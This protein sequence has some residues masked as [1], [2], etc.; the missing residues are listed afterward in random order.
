[1]NKLEQLGKAALRQIVAA[2]NHEHANHYDFWVGL[3]E[4]A[5]ELDLTKLDNSKEEFDNPWSLTI[6]GSELLEE[7]E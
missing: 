4:C 5:S 7:D 2:D 3:E 6:M 1:M